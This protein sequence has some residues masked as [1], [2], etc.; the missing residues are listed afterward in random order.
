MPNRPARSQ[1]ARGCAGV[2]FAEVAF[3]ATL[4]EG[5]NARMRMTRIP[6]GIQATAVLGN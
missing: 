5:K 6:Q 2:S 4:A 1:T 3:R